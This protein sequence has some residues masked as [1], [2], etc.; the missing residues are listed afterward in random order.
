MKII[1]FRCP[2]PPAMQ[3]RQVMVDQV[4]TWSRL[5]RLT[6]DP[7]Y[8]TAPFT[9]GGWRVHTTDPDLNWTNWDAIYNALGDDGRAIADQLLG[10]G[11]MQGILRHAPLVAALPDVRLEIVEIEDLVAAGY[12]EAPDDNTE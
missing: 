9:V 5:Q 7:D 8:V 11:P 6:D 1:Q 2:E 10:E 4:N 3:L 12:V